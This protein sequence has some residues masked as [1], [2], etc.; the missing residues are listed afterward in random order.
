[1]L[2]YRRGL[3]LYPLSTALWENLE[4]ARDQVGYPDAAP[5]HRPP[6]DAWPPLLPRPTPDGLMNGV[7]VL[8]SLAWCAMFGWLVLRRRWLGWLTVGLFTSAVVATCGWAYMQWGISEDERQPLAVVEVSGVTLRRGNG[9]MYPRHPDLPRVNR[10]MEARLLHE[11]G[12][13]VQLQFPGG[14]IGWLPRA[15]VVV[16]DQ[17][18]SMEL[19]DAASRR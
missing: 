2:A 1:I 3:R 8:H 15:A 6:G 13:W 4:L 11:R 7:L 18:S 12:G 9:S 16:D 14:E 10:G 5:R 19:I 17:G